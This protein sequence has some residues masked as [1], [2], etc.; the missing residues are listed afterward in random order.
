MTIKSQQSMISLHFEQE[1][2]EEATHQ[3]KRGIQT[4]FQ[5]KRKFNPP[6][7]HNRAPAK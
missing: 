3:A 2:T 6:I 1:K 7:N 5:K 4:D